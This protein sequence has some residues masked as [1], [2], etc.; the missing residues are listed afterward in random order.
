[1]KPIFPHPAQA[2]YALAVLLIAYILSFV[3]RQILSL[4]VGPIR[5]DLDITDFQMSLL[6]F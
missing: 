2:N 3:D 1:M 6:S 5:S 4:M